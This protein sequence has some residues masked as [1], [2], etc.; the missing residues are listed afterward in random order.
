MHRV[1]GRAS[2]ESQ[3][4]GLR[5]APVDAGRAR[6]SPGAVTE[7]EER[8]SDL[9]LRRNEEES[10][11]DDQHVG[12][13]RGERPAP[14]DRDV[15]TDEDEDERPEARERQH[16]DRRDETEVCEQKDQADDDEEQRPEEAAARFYSRTRC[17]RSRMPAPTMTSG[18]TRSQRTIR[19]APTFASRK[20]T[21]SAT[22]K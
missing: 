18:H 1:T 13:E 7:G 4:K 17:A 9:G 14:A 2:V 20:T 16:R 12:G 6:A 3:R 15:E 22:R 8:W 21:P 19:N 5:V 11:R 10:S